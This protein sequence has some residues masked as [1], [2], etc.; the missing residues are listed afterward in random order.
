MRLRR[1]L[2]PSLR[3]LLAHK[4]RTGLAVGSVAAG[5]AGVLLTGALGQGAEA[6]VRKSLESAG[7]NLL[8]V[9]PAQVQRSAARRR[10]R[11]VVTTL[12]VDDYRAIADLRLV[13]EAAPGVDTTLRVRA[14]TGSMPATVLG[15][16]PVLARL[17]RLRLHAG[18]FFDAED[19][20][21]SRRVA[22]LGARAARTLF[23]GGEPVGEEIRLRGIPFQVIG[24]LE[25]R[26]A[27]ADGSDQDGN[28]FIPAR[29][30]LRRVLNTTWLTAVFVSVADRARMAEASDDVRGTLRERH[31]LPPDAPDDFAVQDQ[32][33]LLAVREEAIRSLS[34]LTTGLA[35][36]SMIL[37]GAG[38]LALMFLSVKERTA[39]IGLRMAVGA[40]STDVFAQFLAE[41][42][43]VA[44]AGWSAG[45]AAAAAAGATVAL[46]T[47]WSL[48]FPTIPALATL[49][50]ALSIGAGFGALPA[51]KAARLTP[52]QALRTRS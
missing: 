18:R 22:V 2:R 11:G 17:R 30:A 44:L 38:I 34:L 4:L 12:R 46:G 39:E 37:G 7:A 10:M 32:A 20:A 41:A 31:R 25:A 36:L 52:I 42:S 8:V 6:D 15:T 51:A 35:S 50:M 45:S 5:V 1:A 14:G 48:A 16:G 24:V 28:V 40:R 47:G 19:D 3:A 43:L 9:R 21:E 49:A 26:G 23:P 33:R 13:T 27:E 29:T